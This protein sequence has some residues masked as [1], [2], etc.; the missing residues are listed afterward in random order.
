MEG[1]VIA[2][3]RTLLNGL[4]IVGGWTYPDGDAGKSSDRLDNPDQLRRAEHAAKLAKARRK[5]GDPDRAAFLVGQE[6]GHD[7][8]I[9]LVIGCEVGHF[10]EHDIGEALFL[11]ARHKA[12]EHRIA[13]EAREAPP[14]QPR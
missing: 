1:N 7:R 5:I 9:A 3:E 8:G 14:D 12:R 2:A 4:P 13:V 11:I 10:L 6:G